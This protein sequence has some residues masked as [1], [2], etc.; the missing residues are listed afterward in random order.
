MLSPD[1]PEIMD[2]GSMDQLG[3]KY[4]LEFRICC[5][6]LGDAALHSAG[7]VFC[8]STNGEGCYPLRTQV[9]EVSL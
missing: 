2:H 8:R 5:G 6:A 7:L 4:C 3:Y 9:T 1:V